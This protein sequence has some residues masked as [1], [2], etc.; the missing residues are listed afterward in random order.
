MVMKILVVEDEASIR[1]FISINLRRAGYEV[2]DFPC[3]EDA[4]SALETVGKADIA[5]LDVMLPGMNGFELCK[6]MREKDQ[7][8]G[9]I[10]LTARTQ[11][12]DKVTGLTAGAD[13]YIT[14]P[15]STSEMVARVDALARRV[16]LIKPETLAHDKVE[17][18]P[19]HLD[20][21]SRRLLKN[22]TE[23]DLTQIEFQLVKLFI[24]NPGRAYSRDEI[25]DEIWGKDYYGNWKTV[26]VNIRRVRQKIEDDASE[27]EFIQTIWGFG[28]RWGKGD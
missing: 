19:F 15:F 13:D 22:D 2:M 9:I 6:I 21:I 14:K 23:V 11:E 20:L 28:Y 24:S 26:D 3:A 27:P 17:Y 18:G 4:L 5:M 25:L 10:M 12:L 1:D 16:Q 8:L 7:A